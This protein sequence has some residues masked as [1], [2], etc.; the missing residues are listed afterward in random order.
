MPP[1]GGDTVSTRMRLDLVYMALRLIVLAVCLV[2]APAPVSG[3]TQT[4]PQLSQDSEAEEARRI[5]DRVDRMLRG[6]S[7]VGTVE[8]TVATRQWNRKTRMKIWSEGTDKVLIRVEQPK[9]DEGTATLRVEQNIWNYLP[10]I[11][12]V[13]RIPTSMMMAAWMG[14]HFTNDDLVKE[15]RLIRDYDIR[16]SFKGNREGIEVYEFVLTPRPEAPVVWGKIVYLI[17][18]A[19]LMPVWA[20][21]YGEDGELKRMAAFSDYRKM[22]GRL[23][24][25]RMR[26]TPQDGSG[27]FTELLYLDLD[28]D[29]KIP[30]RVF[31]LDSLRRS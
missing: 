2:L 30:G 19:D 11:D 12:R 28:F 25:S 10:K 17:R 7:S 18:K 26:M 29:V 20:R 13:I 24:P 23:V 31:T 9:K 27:E 16:I 4:S 22:D 3:V 15:S 6:D 14:S 8:M 1:T 5:I 21:F